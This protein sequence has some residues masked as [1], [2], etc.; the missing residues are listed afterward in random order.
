M[1]KKI[2]LSLL[3]SAP[4][5]LS[6]Q[7]WA[8]PQ[9][10]LTTRLAK[11]NAF[12]ANFK[13]TVISPDGDVLVEGKG[14][15]AIKRPNLFRWNTKTPD[16]NILISDGRTLWY[17][18]PFIEQVTAMWLRDATE[19]TPFVLL[20]RNSAADWQK[21]N[22][23]QTV[24]TF[25]LTPKS[26]ASSMGKFIVTVAKNGEVRS[27]SVIEQDGQRSNFAFSQFNKT[28]PATSL[29]T[30]TPPKGVELDD[31]RQ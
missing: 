18:S 23:S 14:D 15:V 16:E 24:D 28:V 22:V 8:T 17:Y 5:W 31:Q 2:A 4:L 20:T 10:E 25:T 19:Q 9:Q 21:Y 12:T 13:Q 6:A 1:I 29:F 11:V 26:G 3:V 7:A 27:F 30:F